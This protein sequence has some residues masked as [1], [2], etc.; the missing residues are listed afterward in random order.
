MSDKK[1][2]LTRN[3]RVVLGALN[4]AATPLTAYEILDRAG[5]RSEGIKAPLTVYRALER[6]MARG[7]VH[8]I[9]TINAFVACEHAP[10]AEPSGFAICQVCRRA[11]ELRLS[12]CEAHLTGN[13]TSKGFHVEAIRVE[14]T[15]RCAQCR[16]GPPQ[17]AASDG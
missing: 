15:G 8:R 10:H 6:L 2:D 11:T 12:D 9:E 16:A 1:P 7:L 13:A 14:L 17:R 3:Q 4:E 5:V